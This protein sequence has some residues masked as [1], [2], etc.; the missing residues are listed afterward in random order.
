MSDNKEALK[1]M[2]QHIINDKHEDANSVMHDYF[3]NKTREV[4]G[5][6]NETSTQKPEDNE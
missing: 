1:S 3:V 2:L 6:S 4:A 5:M